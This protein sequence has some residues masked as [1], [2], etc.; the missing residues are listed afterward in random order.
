MVVFQLPPMT[1]SRDRVLKQCQDVQYLMLKTMHL[2]A[3]LIL[4]TLCKY[5]LL[6]QSL[7]RARGT[8][9]RTT[10]DLYGSRGA[11]SIRQTPSPA[12]QR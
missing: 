9:N 11:S 8:T 4:V 7:T 1:I 12:V 5:L 10:N 3:I 6:S 2:D